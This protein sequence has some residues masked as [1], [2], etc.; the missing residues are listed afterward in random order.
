MFNWLIVF[1]IDR[2]DSGVDSVYDDEES[3]PV[4]LP[5]CLASNLH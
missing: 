2:F 1:L 3:E 5:L 4:G